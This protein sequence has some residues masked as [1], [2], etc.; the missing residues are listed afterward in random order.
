[1]KNKIHHCRS[2]ITYFQYSKVLHLLIYQKECSNT[3]KMCTALT[4]RLGLGKCFASTLKKRFPCHWQTKKKI[5]H[6]PI[7]TFSWMLHWCMPITGVLRWNQESFSHQICRNIR[8]YPAYIMQLLKKNLEYA[9]CW[10][11]HHHQWVWNLINDSSNHAGHTKMLKGYEQP[12]GSGICNRSSHQARKLRE[13]EAFLHCTLVLM[14]S[15][16]VS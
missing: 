11:D 10:S 2:H 9:K 15:P 12:V 3:C 1:M 5:T 14:Q 4:A 6:C 8:F 16:P 13:V 7:Q